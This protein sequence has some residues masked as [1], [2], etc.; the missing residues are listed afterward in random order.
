MLQSS[1]TTPRNS[2]AHDPLSAF[3]PEDQGAPEELPPP[4]SAPVT[5]TVAV[6]SPDSQMLV[7]TLGAKLDQAASEIDR[8]TA[9]VA[10]LR[11]E[12]AS[13]VAR[14]RDIERQV[15][16]DEEIGTPKPVVV[17]PQRHRFPAKGIRGWLTA[18]L[19]LL[20]LGAG[21]LW[22][23]A[24]APSTSDRVQPIASPSV[25]PVTAAAPLAPA[26]AKAPVSDRRPIPTRARN[27]V[28]A[29]SSE[30][31]EFLGTLAVQTTP[32]GAA[33]LVNH[34]S[35]GKTPLRLPNL[36]AGSHLIWI[37]L[38]GYQRWTRVVTVPADQVTNVSVQLERQ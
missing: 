22:R 1:S 8:S 21:I 18:A 30:A 17:A 15:Y 10:A 26:A 14:I 6:T 12:L 36:R 20:V 4:N 28:P 7:A 3:D 35:V 2:P 16:K 9:E 23:P 38:G 5:P 37:E 29:V 27:V 19:V 25:P 31:R 24:P 34:K 11:G 13:I 32:A 33:V